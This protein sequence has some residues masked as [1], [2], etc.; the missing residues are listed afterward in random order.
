MPV[1]FRLIAF[2]CI[3]MVISFTLS[4]TVVYGERTIQSNPSIASFVIHE[5][6]YGDTLWEL[7]DRYQTSIKLIK[8]LNGLHQDNLIPGQALLIPGL[9]YYAAKGESLFDIANRHG[10]S[11]QQ[12]IQAN[13]LKSTDIYPGQKLYIPSIYQR[14][15]MTGGYVVPQNKE[16][17]QALIKRYQRVVSQIG[18]FEYHPDRNGN[19][20]RLSDTTVI[21]EAWR[22]HIY[23][24]AVVTNLTKKGFDPELAHIILHDPVTRDR[25]IQNIRDLLRSKDYK[26]VNIDFEGLKP[27]DR[28]A[29]NRFM[30][31]LSETLKPIGFTLSIAVPPKQGDAYPSYHGAYDYRTLGQIVDYM[32]LMTYDWHWPGTGPGPIA[33]FGQVRETVKYAVKVVPRHKLFIGIPIYAYDWTYGPNGKTTARAYSQLKAQRLALKHQSTILYHERDKSPYFSYRDEKGNRHVVW[34]EDARSIMAKYRLMNQYGLRGMG[35]WRLGLQFP[36]AEYMLAHFFQ[37]QKP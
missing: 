31:K 35:G 24:V 1:K 4:P 18:V 21:R 36:Q 20:S 27:D 28:K 11:T 3:C 6:R 22:K 33:P 26:G 10:L 14:T 12:L 8:T 37:I 19:L 34:F 25:L 23:P 29:F 7:A 30:R 32:F 2:I 16:Q 15:I 9:H 17:D 5:V 13:K